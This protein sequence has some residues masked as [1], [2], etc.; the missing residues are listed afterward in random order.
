MAVCDLLSAGFFFGHMF[1]QDQVSSLV[2]VL[3][4]ESFHIAS[5]HFTASVFSGK[6]V[7]G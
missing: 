6:Q 4:P 2:F 7:G 5:I 1:P 3:L